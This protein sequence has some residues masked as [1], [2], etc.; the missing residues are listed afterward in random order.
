MKF[1]QKPVFKQGQ[2]VYYLDTITYNFKT[3]KGLIKSAKTEE[4]DGII[5]GKTIKKEV[6]DI[7]YVKDGYYT[8]DKK[9]EPDYYISA[10]KIKIIKGER[11][12]TDWAVMHIAGIPTPILTP[13]GFFPITNK[14]SSGVHDSH[15][16]REL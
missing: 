7:L 13:Y 6:E 16:E 4:S 11:I 10:D 5:R 15:L 2:K 3:K 1:F 12:I 9:E 14:R 8:T